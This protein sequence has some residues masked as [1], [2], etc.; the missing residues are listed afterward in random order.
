LSLNQNKNMPKSHLDPIDQLRY[1]L[2]LQIEAHESEDWAE[3]ERLET[4]INQ[5]GQ[6]L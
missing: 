6:R 5:L 1:Y 2:S 4:L 3:Y